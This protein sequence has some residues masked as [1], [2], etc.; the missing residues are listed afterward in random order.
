MQHH[1]LIIAGAGPA[2]CAAAV[3]SRRLGLH[4]LLIDARGASGGLAKNAFSLENY[5]GAEHPLTGPAF[6]RRLEEYLRRFDIA[7]HT[8]HVTSVRPDGDAWRVETAD[9]RFHARSVVLATGTLPR[10]LDIPGVPE[11]T[12]HRFNY[13][14]YPALAH[15]PASALVVGGG[16]AAFDYALSLHRSGAKVDIIIRSNAPKACGRLR[17][18]VET[19]GGIAI[20]YGC[21]PQSLAVTS[22]GVRLDYDAGGARR[23]FAASCCIAAIGRVSTAAHMLEPVHI[24]MTGGTATDAAGLFVAGDIRR[25][26]LG[27]AGIALGD[28]LEAAMQI[29]RYLTIRNQ[30]SC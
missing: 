23:S 20:H 26:T 13:E 8:G 12:D 29:H 25:T 22:G 2:G 21:A 1:D 6:V 16:E 11:T 3:Q 17:S 19:T 14:V 9:Q 28:G 5:P 24:S 30:S 10:P 18:M 27:Q 4:P 7:V 15:A